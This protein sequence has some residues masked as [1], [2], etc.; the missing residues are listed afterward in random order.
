VPTPLP[1][2]LPATVARIGIVARWKPVHLGHAAV[3]EALVERLVQGAPV[4]D[5]A[6]VAPFRRLLAAAEH[7]RFQHGVILK[8]SERAFGSG[9]LIPITHAW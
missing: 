8:V 7:K 3:L 1:P 6:E 2:D 9:R 4:P 5:S